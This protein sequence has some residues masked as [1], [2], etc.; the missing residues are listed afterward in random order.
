MS[1]RMSKFVLGIALALSLAVTPAHAWP[2]ED[3]GDSQAASWWAAVVDLLAPLFGLDAPDT[4]YSLDS[5]GDPAYP[6]PPST[7]QSDNSCSIH[8]D[9]D[10]SACLTPR[11]RGHAGAARPV[12]ALDILSSAHLRYYSPQRNAK[13][14]PNRF[15]P[16]HELPPALKLP[17]P[18]RLL[19]A[20]SLRRYREPALV[21]HLVEQCFEHRYGDPD[22]MLDHAE[23][24]VAV[25]RQLP[26]TSSCSD[27]LSAPTSTSPTPTAA[28]ASSILRRRAWSRPKQH[29][30]PAPRSRRSELRWNGLKAPCSMTFATSNRRHRTSAR[31]PSFTVPSVTQKT[32]LPP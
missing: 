15:R 8:P 9:G 29:G 4:S 25:A 16:P 14:L 11:G 19:A 18:R 12:L 13:V 22:K 26:S 30:H 10:P 24:A 2:G 7:L 6:A 21:E 28:V 5:N 17:H 32:A 20:G 27:L 3:R 31:L 23:L 1:N